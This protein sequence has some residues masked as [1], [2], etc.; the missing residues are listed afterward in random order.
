MRFH[1]LFIFMAFTT[2][3][4]YAAIKNVPVYPSGIKVSFRGEQTI[5]TEEP[6]VEK[7]KRKKP[8]MV[9][10][11]NVQTVATPRMIRVIN[12]V[13]GIQANENLAFIIY[14]A[15]DKA[16]E[17]H[18][19]TNT[20]Q[21]SPTYIFFMDRQ[22][23]R[24]FKGKLDIKFLPENAHSFSVAIIDK[25]NNITH[26]TSHEAYNKNKKILVSDYKKTGRNK[27]MLQFEVLGTAEKTLTRIAAFQF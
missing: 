2:I 23:G 26:Q 4:S 16:I 15:E 25:K 19:I 6:L 8:R 7:R 9:V 12:S 11:T 3:E 14:D 1:L 27:T 20:T 24:D 22:T 5:I 17:H 13:K 21:P 18:I 10:T